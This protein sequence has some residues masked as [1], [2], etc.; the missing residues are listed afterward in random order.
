[1]KKKWKVVEVGD[2][3]MN[4][5]FDMRKNKEYCPENCPFMGIDLHYEE[6]FCKLF[7]NEGLVDAYTEDDCVSSKRCGR[8]KKMFP[9]GLMISIVPF[10]ENTKKG[11]EI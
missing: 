7:D 3:K 1:M 4:I 5:T 6:S 8:C 9:D 2:V 10:T 11:V